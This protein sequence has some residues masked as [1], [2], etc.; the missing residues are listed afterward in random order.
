M[1]C[2]QSAG[3]DKHDAKMIGYVVVSVDQSRVLDFAKVRSLTKANRRCSLSLAVSR[4]LP[5]SYEN[6]TPGEASFVNDIVF[7]WYCKLQSKLHIRRSAESID[8]VFARTT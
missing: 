1:L 3:T 7:K 6:L 8:A 5:I 2:V 4:A